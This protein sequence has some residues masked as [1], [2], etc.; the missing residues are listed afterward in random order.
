MNTVIVCEIENGC[1]LYWILND[2]REI[3]AGGTWKPEK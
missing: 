1:G 3:I 2:K